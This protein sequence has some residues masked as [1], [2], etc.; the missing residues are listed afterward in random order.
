MLGA[1]DGELIAALLDKTD[2]YVCCLEPDR[3]KVERTRR[4]LDAA[5][6]YG[7]RCVVHQGNFNKLPY[8]PYFA[9]LIL[10]G[11]QLGTG[12]EPPNY[13]ELYRVLRPYGGVALQL[14]ATDAVKDVLFGLKAAGVSQ[15]ELSTVPSGVMIRRGKIPGAGDWSHGY[16][17]I[18]RTSS[19]GDEVVK[20]PLGVLWFGGPGP[21]RMVSRHKR[22]PVPVCAGGVMYVQ[23]EN[24]LIAVDPYNG[25]EMWNLNLKRV[26]RFPASTVGG[27]IVADEKHVY[28][29]QKD[30]CLKVDHS[31][32]IV[33]KFKVPRAG[34]KDQWDYLGITDSHIIGTSGKGTSMFAFGKGGGRSLWQCKFEHT[35]EPISIVSD[36]SLIYLLERTTSR[37][38]RDAKRK[39]DKI[40][41]KSTLKAI[42]I[43]SGETAWEAPDMPRS[44]CALML[45]NGVIVAGPRV[46]KPN[47]SYGDVMAYAAADGRQLWCQGMEK[48][49]WNNDRGATVLYQFIVGDTVY[50]PEAYDLRTGEEKFPL[51]DPFTGKPVQFGVFGINFCTTVS[52]AKN[53]VTYR[54]ASIAYQGI[55]DYTGVKWLP[56]VRPSCW[57]STV[58]AGGLLLAPEGSSTCSCGYNYKTSLAMYPVN[59]TEDWSLYLT[60]YADSNNARFA[61]ARKDKS[62]RVTGIHNS[63]GRSGDWKV[64][65]PEPIEEMRY[66][67]LNMGTLGD[68]V[69]EEKRLWQGYPR[70]KETSLETL[71]LVKPPVVSSKP[72]ERFAWNADWRKVAE[73]SNPWLYASGLSGATT[74]TVQLAPG[75]AHRYSVVL[76]FC[77]PE[78]KTAGQRVFDV[79]I[80]GKK[81]LESFDIVKEAGAPDTAL[82]QTFKGIAAEKAITI[83]LLPVNGAPLLCALEILRDPER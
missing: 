11:D 58:P 30:I 67:R 3:E 17:N 8:N 48:R 74:Y 78:T 39:G 71:N 16:A 52:A 41:F 81:V 43:E 2:S 32:A 79:V 21:A 77:E 51:K 53:I 72:Q 66:L 12:P 37:D 76:H 44:A 80:Q 4:M 83:E 7:P 36:G 64:R 5:G 68:R 40:N 55:D 65:P 1:S 45:K 34:A 15:E 62:I 50:L 18:G 6:L 63:L 25:R 46:E 61:R 22:A 14:S 54:S 13:A 29:L 59:R 38:I 27:N 31:G 20:L 70:N 49:N 10:W 9:N 35:V 26:G 73:T 60:D 33:A 75:G 42:R 57:I 56:E 82:V 47:D 28:C 69:D 19:S 23:G 24:D